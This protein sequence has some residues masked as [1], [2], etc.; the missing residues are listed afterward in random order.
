MHHSNE[1]WPCVRERE[2]ET[3]VNDLWRMTDGGGRGKTGQ[4]T[5]GKHARHWP[6]HEDRIDDDDDGFSFT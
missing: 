6:E 1:R 4:P 5:Y 3:E 2:Q